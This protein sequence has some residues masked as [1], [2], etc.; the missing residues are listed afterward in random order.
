MIEIERL[1]KRTGEST[2][3]GMIRLLDPETKRCLPETLTLLLE[4]VLS[5]GTEV[6]VQV[7]GRSMAPA[8]R[9]GD[10]V[11]IRK[12]R[13]RQLR[14]GDLILFKS[15]LGALVLHRI[16]KLGTIGGT[17]AFHTKGDGQHAYDGWVSRAGVLGRV[18][19][20]EKKTPS[21]A[22]RELDMDRRLWVLANRLMAPYQRL[23]SKLCLSVL[24]RLFPPK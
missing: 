19:R 21:G 15:S 4:D 10:V 22:F 2:T 1:Q 11:V 5:A 13:S 16:L 9:D 24:P 8:I 14:P 23:R 6:K 7:S 20:I 18:V 17:A 3:G 12:I